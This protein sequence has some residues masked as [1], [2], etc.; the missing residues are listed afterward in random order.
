[1]ALAVPNVRHDVFGHGR[2][3]NSA[4]GGRS[5]LVTK[6]IR[7]AVHHPAAGVGIGGFKV[8]YARL[9]HL[10]GKEPRAAASHDTP[11]TV[12]AETGIPGL[13]LFGWLLVSGL[14]LAFR[15]FAPDFAGLAA[16]TL[17]LV[18]ASIAVHSLFYNAF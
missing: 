11:V 13:L 7:I 1:G 6:G 3:L 17:G 5:K 10:K 16:L 2:G 8:A 12:A 4:S 15:R 9:T 18:L 14:L